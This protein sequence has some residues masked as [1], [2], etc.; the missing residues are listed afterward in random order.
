MQNLRPSNIKVIFQRPSCE[1][2]IAV[3]SGFIAGTAPVGPTE[4]PFVILTSN[5][6]G[7]WIPSQLSVI[8]GSVLSCFVYRVQL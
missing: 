5:Q 2:P 1:S 4:V 3:A 7:A 8:R 6:A